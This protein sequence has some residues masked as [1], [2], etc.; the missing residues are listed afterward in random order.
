MA[1]R[2][3]EMKVWILKLKFRKNPHIPQYDVY[4][5]C[6]VVASSEKEARE[7]AFKQMTGDETRV[8]LE[9]GEPLEDDQNNGIWKNPKYSWC[10]EADLTRKGL[11]LT[12]FNAG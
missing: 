7:I 2:N 8:N 10:T 12:S 4:D 1:S 5:K 11:L 6:I 3:G 9:T